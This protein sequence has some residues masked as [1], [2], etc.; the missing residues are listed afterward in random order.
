MKFVLRGASSAA[1]ILGIAGGF[2]TA[3]AQEGQQGPAPQ[4]VTTTQT[5]PQADAPQT[6]ADQLASSDDQAAGERISAHKVDSGVSIQIDWDRVLTKKQLTVSED[7]RVRHDE[8]AVPL[9]AT[10]R[11]SSPSIRPKRIH[12][13][14]LWTASDPTASFP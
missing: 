11:G 10:F 3:I 12:S 8:D 14:H 1:L 7:A 13:R 9:V 4:T 5:S 6:A 2:Q